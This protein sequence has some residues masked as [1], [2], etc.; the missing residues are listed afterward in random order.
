[1]MYIIPLG[2]VG[3]SINDESTYGSINVYV[4]N[5]GENDINYIYPLILY[6]LSL[7]QMFI[8]LSSNA[9]MTQ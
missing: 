6:Q 7:L 8:E 5:W 3:K 4:H 9:C 1:M 2:N